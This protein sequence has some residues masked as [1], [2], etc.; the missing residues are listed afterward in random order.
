MTVKV[1]LEFTHTEDGIDVKSGVVHAADGY[2]HCETAFAA[3]AIEH[4]QEMVKF[5]N[6]ALKADSYF[7]S[8]PDSCVH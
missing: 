1:I 4:V 3:E 6:N 7:M 5:V 2:C 8:A